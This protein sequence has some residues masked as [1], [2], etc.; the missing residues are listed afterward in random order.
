MIRRIWQNSSIWA[1][2]AQIVVSATTFIIAPIISE[3]I[4]IEAYGYVSLAQNILMYIGTIAIA[5]NYFAERNVSVA[6]HKG[7]YREANSYFSSTLV[8]DAV[9]F[10]VIF[11]PSVFIITDIQEFLNISSELEA[12]VKLL[13]VFMLL[14]YFV[15]LFATTY[16]A[17]GVTRNRIDVNSKSKVASS[18]VQFVTLIIIFQIS[19]PH[20]WYVG[21][22]YL[23]SSAI[24]L[25]F[26]LNIKNQVL[27]ELHF[28]R[29]LVSLY[30]IVSQ[31]KNGIWVSFNNL[32][33]ILNDGLDL[34]ITNL[35]I[36][37]HTMG[38]I[39]VAKLFGNFSYAVVVAISN[40]LRASQI[41]AYSEENTDE[42]VRNLKIAMKIT[43][44]VF[45]LIFGGFIGCGEIFLK[46]WLGRKGGRDTFIHCY[47]YQ[48]T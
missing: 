3:K 14:N 45:C 29:E 33:N 11:V 28:E 6:F 4:G 41:K 10:L 38:V 46:L 30:R 12:D 32:G 34:L 8:A 26:Q 36:S 47:L 15:S 42:L 20:I 9:L 19:R 23:L 1:V 17:A 35:M 5:F 16:E 21:L 7:C 13:F 31:V 27:P 2:I 39:S 22:C 43:G 48:P 40:S 25:I 37:E 44:S 24:Y 18:L